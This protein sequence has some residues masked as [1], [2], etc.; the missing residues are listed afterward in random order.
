MD[1]ETILDDNLEKFDNLPEVINDFTDIA[2][3]SEIA[4]TAAGIEKTIDLDISPSEIFDLIDDGSPENTDQIN[5]K[6]ADSSTKNEIDQIAATLAKADIPEPIINVNVEQA[7]IVQSPSSEKLEKTTETVTNNYTI[8][9]EKPPI[10]ISADKPEILPS[11]TIQNT[12]NT[13]T[14]ETAPLPRVS[15]ED[16]IATKSDV[17]KILE[18]NEKL[19]KKEEPLSVEQ[20]DTRSSYQVA[21]DTLGDITK[22]INSQSNKIDSI[23]LTPSTIANSEIPS[24]K[25]IEASARTIT[26]PISDGKLTD[27]LLPTNSVSVDKLTE[28]TKSAKDL[29]E[30]QNSQTNSSLFN[31]PSTVLI[32]M[33]REPNTREEIVNVLNEGFSQVIEKVETTKLNNLTDFSP[34]Q[35]SN[36]Q[37]VLIDG[38]SPILSNAVRTNIDV[39]NMSDV[40]K[41]TQSEL[42]RETDSTNNSFSLLPQTTN[43]T[44]EARILNGTPTLPNTSED[45]RLENN[46]KKLNAEITKNILTSPESKQLNSVNENLAKVQVALDSV[47]ASQVSNNQNISNII[48]STNTITNT[49]G[50]KITLDESKSNSKV[51]KEEPMINQVASTGLSEHYLHAIYDALVSHGIKLRMY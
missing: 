32:E 11:S 50:Q 49:E 21:Q 4:E 23:E 30:I 37:P 48:N 27:S 31:S 29:I 25:P 3:P 47:N 51:E 42:I 39:F 24:V 12:I 38:D 45:A 2:K 44:P 5:V 40:V 46:D 7:N 16:P 1:N 19:I 22:S 35:L 9:T 17:N 15:Q 14:P 6:T 10:I 33:L 18:A 34:S 26:E 43:E 20:A 41:S 36:I 28:L 13:I 8:E